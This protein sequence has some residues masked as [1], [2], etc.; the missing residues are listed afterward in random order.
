MRFFCSASRVAGTLLAGA[1]ALLLERADSDQPAV[2]TAD[3]D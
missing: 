1:L 2:V 3:G